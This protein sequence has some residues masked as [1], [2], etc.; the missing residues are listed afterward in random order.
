MSDTAD[1]FEAMRAERQAHADDHRSDSAQVAVEAINLGNSNGLRVRCH[2]QA[3][4]SIRYADAKGNY[5]LHVYPGN[6]RLMWDSVFDKGPFV[7]VERPW[8]ILDVVKEIIAI[9]KSQ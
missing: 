3:H 1:A 6:Q 5:M 8:T 7:E 4:Y 9:R 2:S